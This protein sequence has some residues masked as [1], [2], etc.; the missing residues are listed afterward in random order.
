[1]QWLCPMEGPNLNLAPGSISICLTTLE[2]EDLRVVVFFPPLLSIHHVWLPSLCVRVKCRQRRVSAFFDSEHFPALGYSLSINVR[3]MREQ[4]ASTAAAHI[5][6][7]MHASSPHHTHTHTHFLPETNTHMTTHTHTHIHTVCSP[8]LLF[9]VLPFFPPCTDV[10]RDRVF[11][12]SSPSS[13]SCCK[14]YYFLLGS[15]FPWGAL[16]EKHLK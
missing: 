16:K 15:F 7:C 1:M 12:S 2:T 9:P 3:T 11:F 5:H 6:E 8:C 13:R 10:L 4:S 14:L